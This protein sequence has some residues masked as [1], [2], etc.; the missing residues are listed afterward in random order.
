MKLGID[1]G[2]T[3]TKVAVLDDKNHL[4]EAKAYSTVIEEQPFL[5]FLTDLI[6]EKIAQ[7]PEISQIGIGIPGTVD[8]DAGMVVWCPA[9]QVENFELCR[10]LQKRIPLP[11]YADNDVNAWALAEGVVGSCQ[12]E[13]VSARGLYSMGRFT[14]AAI[15]ALE[16]LAIWSK[17]EIWY[18]PAPAG[19]SSAHLN[20]GHLPLL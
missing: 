14:G 7:W 15:S 11:V 4:M 2:G 10:V 13:P 16:K 6:R 17:K 9:L 20:D 18:L 5:K 3:K 19:G 1:V 12:M 8:T